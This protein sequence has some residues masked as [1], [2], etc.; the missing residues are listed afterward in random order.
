[1]QREPALKLLDWCTEGYSGAQ[2]SDRPKQKTRPL[3]CFEPMALNTVK[4]GNLTI[5]VTFHTIVQIGRVLKILDWCTKGYSGAPGSDPSKQRTRPLFSVIAATLTW[6]YTTALPIHLSG[7]LGKSCGHSFLVM[8][9]MLTKLW[10]GPIKMIRT[11]KVCQIH[12]ILAE[13]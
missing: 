11:S 12:H 6:S 3:F 10:L 2:A 9:M 8:V 5:R 7:M 13:C 4:N 1:M